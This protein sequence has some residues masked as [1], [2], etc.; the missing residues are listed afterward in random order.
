MA[1]V[2]DWLEQANQQLL[3]IKNLPAGWD[4]YGAYPPDAAIIDSG[5]RLLLAIAQE[6]G[7]PKPH[8]VPTNSG[9][10]QF[11][12]ESGQRYFEIK[13]VDPFTVHFLFEDREARESVEDAM[14]ID[15]HLEELIAY[16]RR[17]AD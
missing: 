14:N 13:I 15:D 4:S 7:V 16:I 17:A 10:V 1:I 5:S 11:E 12:W 8:V 9:G 2:S 6:K 3:A